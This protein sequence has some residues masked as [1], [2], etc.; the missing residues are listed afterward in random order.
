MD[1]GKGRGTLDHFIWLETE[2]RKEQINKEAIMAIFFDVEKT[3]D[4]VWKEGWLIK[5]NIIGIG[6]KNWIKDFLLNRS[7]SVRI[8]ATL[9][10]KYL[11]ENGTPQGS[12]ISPLLFSIL[13]NEV[14]LVPLNINRSLFADDGALWKRGGN[15]E[16][17][18][19]KM[20]EAVNCVEKWSF[21]WGFKFSVEKN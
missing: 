5:L 8:S 10:R 18:K 16:Y 21:L 12:V 19:S 1:S 15:I 17:I 2:I 7:I 11:V 3:Y 6:G 14:F 13:I 9:S 4:M 20:Q